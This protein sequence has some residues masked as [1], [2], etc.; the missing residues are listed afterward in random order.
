MLHL[1]QSD[2]Y[3]DEVLSIEPDGEEEVYDLTV[4][5]HHNFVANN[6]IVH[7]S[8][9]ADADVVMFLY[10]DEVY[11]PDTGRP[12]TA[13]LIVAKHRNGPV[14]EV[15]LL[16]EKAQTRFRDFVVSG[17]TTDRGISQEQDD[18][19]ADEDIVV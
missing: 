15:C 7:N 9:E 2:V 5:G 19:V 6:I 8:I 4:D 14:G 17:S 13:D 10:R 16:F 3:W 1:S 12:N 11:H 18:D